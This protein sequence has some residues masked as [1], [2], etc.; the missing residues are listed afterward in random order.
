MQVESIKS[1][2]DL[3]FTLM[4]ELPNKNLHKFRGKL[5]LKVEDGNRGGTNGQPATVPENGEVFERLLPP[6]V[7]LLLPSSDR[8]V[9][10]PYG[11]GRVCC[12]RD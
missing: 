7:L 6:S 9:Y 1:A 12:G 5:S 3:R 8:A 10:V 11:S 2:M 4:A